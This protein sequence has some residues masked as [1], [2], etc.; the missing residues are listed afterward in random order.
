[1][2][3]LTAD[4]TGPGDATAG[5]VA[6]VADAGEISGPSPDPVPLR[7]CWACHWQQQQPGVD[8]CEQC[9][10]LLDREAE[11]VVVARDQAAEPKT[12]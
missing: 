3:E 1:V 4:E 9:G 6:V 11:P 7:R 10:V 12:W 8:R 5:A 2:P